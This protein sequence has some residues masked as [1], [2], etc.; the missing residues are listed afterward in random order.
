MNLLLAAVF[1]W[2][3]PAPTSDPGPGVA[4]TVRP[5]TAETVCFTVECRAPTILDAAEFAIWEY[6]VRVLLADPN[7][8]GG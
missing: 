7:E 8:V 2:L 5:D 3:T 6:R 1:C 4:C